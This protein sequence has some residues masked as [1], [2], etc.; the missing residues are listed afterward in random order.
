MPNLQAGFDVDSYNK[1][2]FNFDGAF[3]EG[4]G[5]AIIKLGGNN[6]SGNAPYRMNGYWDFVAK[7]AKFPVRGDYWVT[8]GH[9]PKRAAI[10]YAQN[11]SADTNLDL[12]DNETLDSGNPWSDSECCVFFDTLASFKLPNYNPWAYG[13]KIA[14]WR[15][16]APWPGL[17]ARGIKNLTAFYN[18]DPMSNIA[19][20][21]YPEELTQGHQWTSSA[22]IGGS[23]NIDADAFAVGAF[24]TPKPPVPEPT[25]KKRKNMNDYLVVSTNGWFGLFRINP[26]DR[27]KFDYVTVLGGND[28]VDPS[29]P[30]LAFNWGASWGK[31]RA[32]VTN[33]DPDLPPAS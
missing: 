31:F 30:R 3:N 1:P 29:I 23:R 15:S 7:R 22:T 20:S 2:N 16:W 6:L 32:Q 12:L 26:S 28:A 10:F 9:D 25:R 5:V 27:S 14:L 4:Y 11:R 18:G 21:A 33:P 24:D 17:A 19:T 8:G 13:S